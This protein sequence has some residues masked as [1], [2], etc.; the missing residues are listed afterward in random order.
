MNDTAPSWA[1]VATVDEPPVLVQS[2]VAWHL[3]LGAAEIFLYFDRPDDPAA[4]MFTRLPQ[5]HVIRCD[6][7]H[8]QALGRRPG[9]HQVRQTQNATQAYGRTQCDWLLHIDADEFLWPTSAVGDDLAAAPPVDALTVPVAER[10]YDCT[11]DNETI[12]AGV[13]RRPFTSD[14]RDNHPIF[15]TGHG[16]LSRGLTG[17]TIGKSFVRAGRDL[18]VAIH[19]PKLPHG[20]AGPLQIGRMKGAV[21]LHFEGLTPL[22]WMAKLMRA[23]ATHP[24]NPKHTRRHRQ[25]LRAAAQEAPDEARD[26]HDLLKVA[27]M[28]K[29]RALSR[30][31][32]LLTAQFD[33][34]PALRRFFPTQS[35]DLSPVAFDAWLWAERGD[36]LRQWAPRLVERKGE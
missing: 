12:F 24:P 14:I 2:F 11:A 18:R 6:E 30:Y 15:D 10:I 7:A 26:L 17:H 8:W 3:S 34:V 25:K 21:L 29:Q 4:D 20:V 32:L 9:R 16:V 22:H 36:L 35:H 27:D 23:G 19:R 28:T 1:V 33:P 31:G 5:V 13:F